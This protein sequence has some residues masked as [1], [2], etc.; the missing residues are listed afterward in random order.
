[1]IVLCRFIVALAGVMAI[2]GCALASPVSPP[3]AGGTPA[4][5]STAGVRPLLID[6]DVA[7]DD[8]VA[9]AFL[10]GSRSRP[11]RC[12]GPARRTAPAAWTW[13]SAC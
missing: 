9:I 2:G 11:S 6:T 7:P 3:P 4:S 12:L 1:M 8:L 5:P 10:R 13:C